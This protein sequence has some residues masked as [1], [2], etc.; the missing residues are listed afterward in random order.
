MSDHPAL[1]PRPPRPHPLEC[2]GRG[3]RPCVFDYWRRAVAD[4]EAECR[5]RG[6]DPPPAAHDAG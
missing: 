2:C 1:P 6:I 3:C 5:R 4:W